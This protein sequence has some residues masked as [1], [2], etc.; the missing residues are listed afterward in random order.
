V[1]S[2]AAKLTVRILRAA[3]NAAHDAFDRLRTSRAAHQVRPEVSAVARA[4][5]ASRQGGR[6][7]RPLGLNIGSGPHPLA[8]WLNVDVNSEWY[9]DVV[10][11]GGRLPFRDATFDRCY[12]GHILEHLWWGEQVTSALLEIRRVCRPGS[13]VAVVGPCILKAV[14]RREPRGLLLDIVGR[15]EG[16]FTPADHKWIPTERLTAEALRLGGLTDIRPVSIQTLR[17]PL[18]PNVA[19]DSLWQ[20]ALLARTP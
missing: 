11:D 8:G 10:G 18:W 12:L 14:G 20:A 7:R 4:D 2:S 15:Q 17:P 13:E 16:A 1:K 9:P 6:L 19:P 3:D 5:L